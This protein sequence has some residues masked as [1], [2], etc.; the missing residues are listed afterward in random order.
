[1]MS[2]T[3]GLSDEERDARLHGKFIQMGGLIY[4]MFDPVKH[5]VAPLEDYNA[6]LSWN[7]FVSLDHG[8]RNPTAILWHAVSPLGE[9]ITFDEIYES[10]QLIDYFAG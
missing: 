8:F 1:M 5:V 6:I 10:G 7:W 3:A 4:P 2:L 9:V